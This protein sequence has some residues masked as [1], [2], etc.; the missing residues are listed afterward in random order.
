[1]SLFQA[2]FWVS[3]VQTHV[4]DCVLLL[5]LLFFCFRICCVLFASVILGFFL[6]KK[7]SLMRMSVSPIFSPA[8]WSKALNSRC[9]Q[10]NNQKGLFTSTPLKG[11][12]RDAISLSTSNCYLL[13]VEEGEQIY[14]SW[15]TE[16]LTVLN[17][18]HMLAGLGE[19]FQTGFADFGYQFYLVY[20]FH[21][22]C[23]M[24]M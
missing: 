16:V 20:S 21:S 23:S 1:M 9:S 15:F 17:W 24:L 8:D 2:V 14:F 13:G 3:S 22:T 12:S 6:Y 11:R 4:S 5:L 18:D 7:A 19:L 10:T